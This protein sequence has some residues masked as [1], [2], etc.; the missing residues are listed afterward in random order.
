MDI[1]CYNSSTGSHSVPS[2]S[3]KLQHIHTIQLLHRPKF[4]HGNLAL[5]FPRQSNNIHIVLNGAL[6]FFL[7]LHGF[8]LHLLASNHGLFG[9]PV[10]VKLVYV[11]NVTEPHGMSLTYDV[12]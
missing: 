9:K 7:G 8:Y 12:F 3:T 2:Q 11:M 5:I 4:L 1:S 6:P 10:T